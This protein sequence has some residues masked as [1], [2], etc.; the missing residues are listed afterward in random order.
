MQQL[1]E[2]GVRKC[3]TNSPA[4]TKAS[5]EGWGGGAPGTGAEI[6]L[7]PVDKTMLTQ[8]VPLQPMEGYSGADIHTAACGGPAL[9]QVGML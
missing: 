2:R 4:D 3:E 8:V 1:G 7:Q 6:S 9:E 5:K